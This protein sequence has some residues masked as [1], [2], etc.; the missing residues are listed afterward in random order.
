[1][2]LR[3]SILLFWVAFATVP[4]VAVAQSAILPIGK[5][6]AEQTTAALQI[7]MSNAL[8]DNA[9]ERDLVSNDALGFFCGCLAGIWSGRG[10][11]YGGYAMNMRQYLQADHSATQDCKRKAL[12]TKPVSVYGSLKRIA[13]PAEWKAMIAESRSMATGLFRLRGGNRKADSR[14]A[15]AGIFLA[16]GSCS[17]G[18]DTWCD[19]G[20]ASSGR[21]SCEKNGGQWRDGGCPTVGRISTCA[22]NSGGFTHSYS[23]VTLNQARGAC[24]NGNW[25]ETSDSPLGR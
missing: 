15:Q 24:K 17:M 8:Y 9:A 6:T 20:G 2:S 3:E 13:T 22:W 11:A 18:A 19:D 5:W 7:C 21:K 16:N 10:A 25:F 4:S 1:M 12:A 23:H 14:S